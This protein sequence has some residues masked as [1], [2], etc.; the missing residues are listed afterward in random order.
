MLTRSEL[1][2]MARELSIE[3]IHKKDEE[4]EK[5]LQEF[6]AELASYTNPATNYHLNPFVFFYPEASKRHY[7]DELL[8]FIEQT[9]VLSKTGAA[10][11]NATDDYYSILHNY[12][13]SQVL[14]SLS[15]I[16]PLPPRDF[17][18]NSAIAAGEGLGEGKKINP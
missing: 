6:D 11:T 3:P 9:E 17:K 8:E 12:L 18:K 15:R 14:L 5:I 7:C 10:N 13:I 16:S 1:D 2:E 4:R